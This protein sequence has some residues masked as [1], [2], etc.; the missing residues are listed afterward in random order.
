[1]KNERTRA[2]VSAWAANPAYLKRFS[3]LRSRIAKDVF[4]LADLARDHNDYT[5]DKML[6]SVSILL[7]QFDSA[8]AELIESLGTEEETG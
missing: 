1:M 3:K 6:S 4:Q 5:A 7:R 2:R 8:R